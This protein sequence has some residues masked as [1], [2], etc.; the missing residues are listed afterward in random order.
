MHSASL[1]T[2]DQFVLAKTAME[3]TQKS[4]AIQLAV[5]VM[6]NV[7]VEKLVSTAIVSALV[8][9]PTHALATQNVMLS[10]V[11]QS[12]VVPADIVVTLET[13]AF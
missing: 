6:L 12:V 2:I 4:P 3:V 11:V 9:F 1:I 8:L 10:V 13:V 5:E 7:A